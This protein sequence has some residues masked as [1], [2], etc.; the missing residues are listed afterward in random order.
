MH[1]VYNYFDKLLPQSII[2]FTARG[3]NDACFGRSNL[4]TGTRVNCNRGDD[5][6]EVR[7]SD[8]ILMVSREMDEDVGVICFSKSIRCI[9]FQI[10][11]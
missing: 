5:V 1:I 6:V 7:L 3:C 4:P 10:G 9:S 11:G 8:C 2:E